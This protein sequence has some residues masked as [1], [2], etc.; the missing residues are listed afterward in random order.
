M[1]KTDDLNEPFSICDARMFTY[2]WA[3]QTLMLHETQRY[4]ATD[5]SSSDM[6][7]P[8]KYYGI[9]IYVWVFTQGLKFILQNWD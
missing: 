7:V 3:N 9:F 1:I 6:G 2:I 4:H 8:E 5:T